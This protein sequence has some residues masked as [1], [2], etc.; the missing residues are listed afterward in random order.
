MLTKM[1]FSI[2]YAKA[3]EGTY[4]C[5]RSQRGLGAKTSKVVLLLQLYYFLL[6]LYY[7]RARHYP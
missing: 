6:L 7:L 5:V 4:V 2:N 3:V 1:D